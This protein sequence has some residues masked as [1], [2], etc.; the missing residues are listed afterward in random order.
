MNVEFP[1]M[2]RSFEHFGGRRKTP[3]RFLSSTIWIA[4]VRLVKPV[5][6]EAMGTTNAVTGDSDGCCQ[7]AI[8]LKTPSH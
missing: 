4:E 3:E 5:R 8:A 1:S 6:V 2:F 7:Q